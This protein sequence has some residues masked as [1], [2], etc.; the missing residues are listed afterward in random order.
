MTASVVSLVRQVGLGF[1]YFIVDDFW[2]VCPHAMSVIGVD[3]VKV[4][5]HG[6]DER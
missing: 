1:V 5:G 4:G 3:R 2:E 6:S